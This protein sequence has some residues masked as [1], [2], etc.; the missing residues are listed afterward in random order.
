MIYAMH[1]AQ[2]N[3]KNGPWKYNKIRLQNVNFSGI[4][5]VKTKQVFT[6][7][8]SAI[9][10]MHDE[11]LVHRNLKAE[12]ILIFD[13]NDF[14]KVIHGRKSCSKYKENFAG[15]SDGFRFD[16]KRERDGEVPGI[17]KLL[18]VAWAVRDRCKWS[19]HC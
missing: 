2:T 18:H 9:E 10:F 15:E 19:T 14:S 1:R 8:M 13:S 3:S 6:A 11:N 16:A 7:V 17:H 5:E 12:N 4:G